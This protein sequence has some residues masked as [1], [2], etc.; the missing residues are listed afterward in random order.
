[1]L[2]EWGQYRGEPAPHTP[3]RALRGHPVPCAS[4]AGA[5]GGPESITRPRLPDRW[6]GRPDRAPG[7]D[8]APGRAAAG[9]RRR[10]DAAVAAQWPHPQP[11]GGGRGAP[12][13]GHLDEGGGAITRPAVAA[14]W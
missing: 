12:L 6:A 8:G 4:P 5:T 2:F 7:R 10:R 14:G 13:V 11:S 3:R 1:W 9:G